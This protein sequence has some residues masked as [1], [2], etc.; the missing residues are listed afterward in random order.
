MIILEHVTLTSIN[1]ECFDTKA[2][3]LW[4]SSATSS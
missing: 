1:P 2:M 4:S 3:W